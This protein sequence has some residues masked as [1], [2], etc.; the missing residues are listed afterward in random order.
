MQRYVRISDEKTARWNEIWH[1]NRMNELREIEERDHIARKLRQ[2]D[3]C[4]HCGHDLTTK[5]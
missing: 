4:P 1:R 5:R 2:P 3:R